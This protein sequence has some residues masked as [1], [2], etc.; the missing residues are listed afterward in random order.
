MNLATLAKKAQL[1]FRK[2]VRYF[3]CTESLLMGSCPSLTPGNPSGTVSYS[4]LSS[5]CRS[6]GHMTRLAWFTGGHVEVDSFQ[7]T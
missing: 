3:V 5:F 6:G 4:V 7:Q 1:Y 2:D